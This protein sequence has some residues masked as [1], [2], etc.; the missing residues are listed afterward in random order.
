MSN[1][2]LQGIS[3]GIFPPKW[4]GFFTFCPKSANFPFSSGNGAGNYGNF[5]FK[6]FSFMELEANFSPGNA[7][8]QGISREFGAQP[9]STALAERLLDTAPFSWL[10]DTSKPCL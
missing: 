4:T 2:L 6:L 3:E 9:C 7:L 10:V 1:S 5:A 8:E